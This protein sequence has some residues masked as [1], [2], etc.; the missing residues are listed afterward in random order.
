MP[1]Y[2]NICTDLLLVTNKTSFVLFGGQQ[3]DSY[4]GSPLFCSLFREESCSKAGM[5]VVACL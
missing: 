4:L 5:S 3:G 2:V 1:Y